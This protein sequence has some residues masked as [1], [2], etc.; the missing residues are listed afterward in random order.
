MSGTSIIAQI[1]VP[2]TYLA[3]TFL[4][5]TSRTKVLQFEWSVQI[6]RLMHGHWNGRNMTCPMYYGSY[7]YVLSPSEGVS[8]LSDHWSRAKFHEAFTARNRDI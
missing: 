3:K 4:S 7:Q 5:R 8:Q 1:F 6:L 2:L